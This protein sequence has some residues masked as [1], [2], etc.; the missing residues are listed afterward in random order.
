[1][2]PP[3]RRRTRWGA[4]SLGLSLAVAAATP[5]FASAQ[6]VPEDLA[7]TGGATGA[8]RAAAAPRSV[9]LL[10]YNIQ[11]GA[12]H[13]RYLRSVLREIRSADADIVVLNEIDARRGETPQP[14]WLADR[15]GMQ[16]AFYPNHS[17]RGVRNRGNAILSRYPVLKRRNTLLA[18][19]P[20]TERRGLIRAKIDLGGGITIRVAGTHLQPSRGSNL[21][22]V[23]AQ[24][25]AAELGR[26]TCATFLLGDM[27]AW[28]RSR[29]LRA[30]T[31][32][33]RDPWISGR[34]GEG[35]TKP[36]RRPRGRIDYI[37]VGGRAFAQEARVMPRWSSDHLAVRTTFN[38]RPRSSCG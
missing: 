13:G 15:L 21:K 10:A 24:Q 34:F 31:T 16:A 7:A 4:L 11:N 1:M 6:V 17:F 8:A 38:V 32:G 5:S 9:T 37:L 20:R 35:L 3:T 23:Q 27:N 26:P 33:L 19:Q 22:L 28:P 29:E 12:E 14:Q 30:L 18:Y 2:A 36:S 25:V